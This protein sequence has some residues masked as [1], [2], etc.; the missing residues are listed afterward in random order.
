MYMQKNLI[1]MLLFVD[2]SR[3]FDSI[4]KRKKMDEIIP[5]PGLAK[6]NVNS[7]MML[8]KNMKAMVHSYDGNTNFFN[9]VIGVLQRDT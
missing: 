6:V 4:N 9:I 5:A 1:A 3:V 7:I 2:F 8:Y